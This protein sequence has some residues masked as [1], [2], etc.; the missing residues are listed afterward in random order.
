MKKSTIFLAVVLLISTSAAYLS[1]KKTAEVSNPFQTVD[2]STISV[3]KS[4]VID[5]RSF[6]TAIQQQS[7]DT[8]LTYAEWE[9]SV[10]TNVSNGKSMIYVP[11]TNSSIGIEFFYDGLN[12]EVDS[13]NIVKITPK[14]ETISNYQI[15]GIQTYYESVILAQTATN[16]FSGIINAFSITN[17]FLYNYTYNEGKIRS[18]G[19]AAPKPKQNTIKTDAVNVKT[20]GV[21][22]NDI[23]CDLWGLYVFW[24]DGSVTLEDTWV[25]CTGDECQ[26]PSLAVSIGTGQKYIKVNC[27]SNSDGS[28]FNGGGYTPALYSI[29]NLLKKYCLKVLADKIGNSQ[30]TDQMSNIL[31]QS[32]VSAGNAQNLRF[33]NADL[34]STPAQS[35]KVGSTWMVS[36][37]ENLLQS[38]SQEFVVTVLAHEVAHYYATEYFA[39]KGIPNPPQWDEHAYMFQNWVN[40]ISGLLQSVFGNALDVR[41]ANALALG[42]MEDVLKSTMKP[43]DP[44]RLT[45]FWNDFA[46]KNYHVSLAEANFARTQFGPPIGLGSP[47]KGTPA[48]L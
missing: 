18:H 43:A 47:R 45:N 14:D 7:I 41:D 10:K 40:S 36:V 2:V 23:V 21:K 27:A 28:T 8:L 19:I 39:Q 3:L 17:K 4:W 20:N 22:V 24:D 9:Q 34:G 13:G 25:V 33:A 37:N 35:N 16:K 30:Y 12:K 32:F 31:R 46:L 44:G 48:C 5:Q 1:C 29:N 15:Q 42:G 11:L 6:A 38:A 26:P